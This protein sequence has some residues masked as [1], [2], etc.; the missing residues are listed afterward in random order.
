MIAGDGLEI[1]FDKTTLQLGL[2]RIDADVRFPA[3][4]ITALIGPSGS[5]KSTLLAAIAGFVV[6]K[7]GSISIGSREM[8]AIAPG[9]RPVTMVFQE[10]NLFPH[11]DVSQN[12]GLGLRPSLKPSKAEIA[13]I[14]A[15]LD[16][17]GLLG[18]GG[19]MPANLSGGQIGRVALA[20]A[21]LRKRP[22]LLLDEPFA[23]LGPALRHDMLDLVA[24]VQTED[25]LTVL[26]VT[27]L[28][29][30]AK[31]IAALTAV[32]SDGLVSDPV[33]TGRLFLDPP[34]S[35]SEYLG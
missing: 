22:V 14:D 3:G 21:L 10:H 33:A 7:S 31:R 24:E 17:V 20:R 29:D 18:M 8:N 34:N 13:A 19:R 12:V 27:H 5:G 9:L 28:P 32:V 25:A 2:F 11:L 16:R 1:R 35:L 4:K 30:D 6:P 23:A 26:L 15:A